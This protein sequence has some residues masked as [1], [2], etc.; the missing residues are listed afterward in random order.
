M[1]PARKTIKNENYLEAEKQYTGIA[2]HDTVQSPY[3]FEMTIPQ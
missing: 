1:Y 2:M 3:R